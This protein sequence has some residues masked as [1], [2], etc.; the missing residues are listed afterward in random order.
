M[1][2]K[3]IS[4]NDLLQQVKDFWDRRPCNIRH[5]RLEVG[6]P[7]YFHEVAH[8]R[9]FVEPHIPEFAQ[10]DRWKGKKV[11]EIGCGIGTDTINFARAGADVTAVEFS[12]RSLEIAK[13][14]TEIF[15]LQ[16]RVRFHLVNA[17]EMSKVVPVEPYDLVYSMGVIHHTPSP[18]KVFDEIIKYSNSETEIRVMLYSKWSW[19]VLWI[20]LKFGRGAFWNAK[21][22]VRTY[23][24]AQ[25]GCP[26]THY[27]SFRD[28][29][30]LLRGFQILDIRKAHIF[31]Y[32][33]EKYINYE[34]VL[35][36][37]FAWM[38]DLLFRLLSKILGWH[39]LVVARRIA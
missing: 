25:T 37:Y 4:D 23:S 2:S 15:G 32:V 18:E 29:R 31:P 34:Y 6:T 3:G 14:Q 26:V 7:E 13:R 24:E 1:N 20:I 8:R 36:W 35:E 27:Y 22:L 30:R 38:P 10:F 16:D 19:K 17:E 9:Y 39:T 11:L 21:S 5:S 28:I 12:E 33:I